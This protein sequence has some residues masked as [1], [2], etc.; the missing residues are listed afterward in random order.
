MLLALTLIACGDDD[1]KTGNNANNTSTNNTSTNNTSTNNTSTNNTSTNNTSTNNNQLTCTTQGFEA[2]DSSFEV[3]EDG[4]LIEILHATANAAISVEF[5]P[6]LD[7]STPSPLA[8]PGTYPIA[9]TPGDQNYETCQTCVLIRENCGENGCETTYFATGGSIEV[10]SIDKANNII[11]ATLSDLVLVEV[12]IDA[13]TYSSTPVANG[14]VYCIDSVSLDTTP[15]CLQSTDCQDPT[16]PICDAGVCVGCVTPFDCAAGTAVCAAG[17]CVA[18]EACTG[19]VDE[20][21]NG[22]TEA[23]PLAIGTPANG[24]ICEGVDVGDQDW[25][26][27]S[28]TEAQVVTVDLQWTDEADMDV[29]LLAEDGAGIARSEN[30]NPPNGENLSQLL[31]PG[32]YFIVVAPYATAT[33]GGGTAAVAYTLTTSAIAPCTEDAQ[34]TTGDATFCDVPTGICVA[35]RND[36][37]CS[38]VAPVC[39]GTGTAA[40]CS[41]IDQCTDDDAREHK[42]DG[43]LGATTLTVGTGITGRICGAA[44]TLSAA[45]SD[46]FTFTTDAVSTITITASWTA[47]DVDLDFEVY[48]DLSMPAIQSGISSDNP[49]TVE[50]TDLPAG[51]YYIELK[52]YED[53]GATLDYDLQ[54]NAL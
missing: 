2:G 33:V 7:G 11:N 15:E 12:T 37:D 22:P 23:T 46:W 20:T 39:V 45:E 16:K 34:C 13:E 24:G 26:T 50:L 38:D 36:L 10:A 3:F 30:E 52:S 29:Y 51:T 5:Y 19:D 44:F 49:E 21:N 28:L 48:G 40:A 27:F 25:F 53:N 42:D 4:E 1:P 54:V 35:C 32:N 18:G 6:A 8:G 31:Q 47:M 14:K 9:A 41:V 43:P 17:T